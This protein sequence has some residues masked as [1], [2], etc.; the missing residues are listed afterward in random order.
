MMKTN[1]SGYLTRKMEHSAA[2]VQS[3]CSESE[4][5]G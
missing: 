4:Q 3:I 1:G 5:V 2:L